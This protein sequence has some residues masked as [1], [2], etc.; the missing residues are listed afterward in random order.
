MREGGAVA[1]AAVVPVHRSEQRRAMMYAQQNGGV[2]PPSYQQQL[3]MQQM[4][5]VPP[6]VVVASPRDPDPFRIGYVRPSVPSFQLRAAGYAGPYG[7]GMQ[8]AQAYGYAPYG[9]P[10]SP[11]HL[12]AAPPM[13]RPGV[14][15]SPYAAAGP[16]YG[17][18]EYAAGP[19]PQGSPPG[20]GDAGAYGDASRY[21][22]HTDGDGGVAG[23]GGAYPGDGD[24]DGDYADGDRPRPRQA[25][26]EEG[27]EQEEEEDARSVSSGQIHNPL[28]I[29]S[30]MRPPAPPRPGDDAGLEGG[31]AG[32]RAGE[33]VAAAAVR[34]A[35][36]AA[37]A[38]A[39]EHRRRSE[40]LE[41][42]LERERGRTVQA[43]AEGAD[44]SAR[45]DEALESLGTAVRE[46]DQALAYAKSVNDWAEDFNERCDSG[47]VRDVRSMLTA[48]EER[49]V[50]LNEARAAVAI[51]DAKLTLSQQ[52]L[53]ATSIKYRSAKA[54][55][56]EWRHRYEADMR[57]A[58]E[59]MSALLRR[60]HDDA[61]RGAGRERRRGADG[62][63][64]PGPAIRAAPPEADG[65]TPGD[66]GGGAAA[67]SRSPLRRFSEL[68]K[69]LGQVMLE[70]EGQARRIDRLMH[71][72]S[73]PPPP[74]D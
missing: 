69:T 30:P 12:S 37:E 26:D 6:P 48:F 67:A 15:S 7:A 8:P 73:P 22:H 66:A 70:A 74:G 52:E 2:R 10:G 38:E 1:R 40:E 57:A 20:N 68:E 41:A 21:H 33:D 58:N 25:D 39:A 51:L 32:D 54:K 36:A 63:D 42:E 3:K 60:Q 31:S 45:L 16:A 72:R 43:M 55:L 59:K 4:R 23:T 17:G 71:E 49:K 27:E 50:E 5:Q 61:R 65:R 28:A 64:A 53:S 24:G 19:V 47:D 62:D 14:P 9:A 18:Y 56:R 11:A 29:P 44:A 34:D 35:L 46:R 13:A